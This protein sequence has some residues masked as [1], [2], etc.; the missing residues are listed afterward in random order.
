MG[1]NKI[2]ELKNR[3]FN[4]DSSLWP[5]GNVSQNRLGWL[6]LVNKPLEE[7]EQFISFSENLDFQNIV[8]L[9]MGGSSL[10]PF[11]LNQ[12]RKDPTRKLTVLDTT[13]PTVV[14]EI[15]FDDALFIVSSKSGTTLE[16]NVMFSYFYDKIKDPKRFIAITDPST[17]LEK[18]A[19]ELG[20]LKIF[21]NPPDIGGR[22]SALSYFGLIPAILIGYDPFLLLENAKKADIDNAIALGIAMGEAYYNKQ[23]KITFLTSEK[24]E[25]VGLW[26]EQL[27]AESTGK[28]QKGLI[29]VPTSIKE[30]GAD[31]FL[32]NVDLDNEDN[33]GK[34]FY[35]Y[36]IAT[37]IAGHYLKIDPFNEPN[38][39][40]SKE[41]TNRVLQSLPIPE[42]ENIADLNTLKSFLDQSV[43]PN[44]YISLQAYIPYGN[45]KPLEDLRRLL[46][47][48]YNVAV[49]KGYGPRF[50]HSTGQLHKGGPNSVVAIQILNVPT[51]FKVPIPNK[52]YDFNTLIA[53][54]ALGDYQ[55]LVSHQRRVI[56][57]KSSNLEDVIRVLGG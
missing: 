30:T 46:T 31:R 55:S 34:L 1:D 33:L 38:V 28:D 22:Y 20:F 2:I 37:A 42:N 45:D 25:V 26:L 56:R 6:D 50:L 13:H 16:P 7:L 43:K 27:I 40:E 49:T 52:N 10:A 9:G 12:L 19:R 47:G 36:E 8:L 35:E 57:I 17:A 48:L 21:I 53:A 3:L 54:Q 51:D 44:D 5:E 14:S 41:N 39:A 32:I 24:L 15:K 18:L 23:D 11:V 4:K 29:P